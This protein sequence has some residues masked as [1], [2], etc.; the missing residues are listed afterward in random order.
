[1]NLNNILLPCYSCVSHKYNHTST[2]KTYLHIKPSWE[3]LKVLDDDRLDDLQ[4]RGDHH[5]NSAVILPEGL[6]VLCEPVVVQVE[7]DVFVPVKRRRPEDEERRD[8]RDAQRF[9]LAPVFGHETVESVEGNEE[10][11]DY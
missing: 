4:I 9:E 7:E 1:M 5:R 11:S 3:A 2:C 6:A 10:C 8:H